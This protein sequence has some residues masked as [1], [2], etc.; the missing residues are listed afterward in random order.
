[1]AGVPGDARDEAGR[2][3]DGRMIRVAGGA[4]FVLCRRPSRMRRHA[5]QWA[6]PGGR[7]D[8]DETPLEAALRELDEELGLR[9]AADTALGLLDDYA[10][11]SGFVVTPVV[12]WCAGEV[13]LNPDP[14][15]VSAAYRI[16]LHALR[17][18]EPRF[19][20]IPESDRRVLQLPL[21]NDLIHAPTA[22]ILYQFRE[23]ALRGRPGVRV[24]HVEEPVFA[25][26]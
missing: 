13:T 7:L 12:L 14:A 21:G 9:L 6:L 4:A 23:V 11:R 19:V 22:A 17:D 2:P 25:W 26:R 16:G 1:M 10:T 24:D 15:E 20:A 3:L 8:A 18:S 5:G